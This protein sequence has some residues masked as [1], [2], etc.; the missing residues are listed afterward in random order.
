MVTIGHA[1]LD[2]VTQGTQLLVSATQILNSGV[3]SDQLFHLKIAGLV[4]P[5]DRLFLQ[6][7]PLPLRLVSPLPFPVEKSADF[8]GPSP[9]EPA[10]SPSAAVRWRTV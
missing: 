8:G 2:L 3:V 10:A 6:G 7:Q 5:S 9:A 4:T 1:Q